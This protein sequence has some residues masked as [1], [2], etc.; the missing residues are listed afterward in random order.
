MTVNNDFII[1][2]QINLNKQPLANSDLALYMSYLSHGIYLDKNDILR[3][4]GPFRTNFKYTLSQEE[5]DDDGSDIDLPTHNNNPLNMGHNR[6]RSTSE[7]SNSSSA[8]G[9]SLHSSNSSLGSYQSSSHS[10]IGRFRP[11]NI[12]EQNLEF[13][14]N[15]RKFLNKARQNSNPRKQGENKRNKNKPKGWVIACQEPN[16]NN[17]KLT[18]L[19]GGKNQVIFDRSARQPRA[20]LIISHTIQAWTVDAWTDADMATCRIENQSQ[21]HKAIYMCSVYMDIY[22][23]Q[24]INSKLKRLTKFCIQNDFA[25]VVLTDCNSHSTL[26]NM[27][28]TNARGRI[29]EGFIA[30]T[31]LQVLNQGNE[32]TFHREGVGTIVDVTLASPNMLP[33]V[34]NWAIQNICPSSD[35]LAAQ[36]VIKL[37][38]IE[39]EYKW[40]LHRTN[41]E[42]FYFDIENKSRQ[43]INNFNNNNE[44]PRL[45]DPTQWHYE[46]IE[47]VS[48]A[49]EEDIWHGIVNNGKKVIVKPSA[50][51][52]SW[53]T[54]E[55][56]DMKLKLKYISNAIRKGRNR[57]NRQKQRQSRYTYADF[58]KQKKKYKYAI[59]AAR[60]KSFRD[61]M[62]ECSGSPR[63]IS[64]VNKKY[65]KNKLLPHWAR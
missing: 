26:W 13:Q 37:D 25:L 62:T 32:V 31:G 63:D 16:Y 29:M 53:F 18:H 20:A 3:G 9:H 27:P 34:S 42:G 24:V 57:G 51:N 48:E 6:S 14:Q 21:I 7:S 2:T 17:G 47:V 5:S 39:T 10:S 8:S 40:N 1:T 54:K 33:L 45:S 65:S 64:N 38:A 49:I 55:L 60:K 28:H 44:Y 46:R 11:A 35:H 43:E 59:R 23:N 50:P 4:M 19:E 56:E 36:M 52:T 15:L 12:K 22:N 61:F 58:K 30:E 41:W